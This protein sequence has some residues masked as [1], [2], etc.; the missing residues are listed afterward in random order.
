MEASTTLGSWLVTNDGNVSGKKR[1]RIA[2]HKKKAWRVTSNVEDV[3]QFLETK[4]REERTGIVVSDLPT[5]DLLV[6]DDAPDT[7]EVPYNK[8][9]GPLK[10]RKVREIGPLKCYAILTP[11]SAVNDP[12][13]SRNRVR[14][15]EERID[16]LIK[17]I[18]DQRRAQG[19]IPKN[20]LQSMKDHKA[21]TAKLA[22]KAKPEKLRSKF[23]FDLWGS[24]GDCIMVGDKAVAVTDLSDEVKTY[25]MEKTGKRVYNRP[26][27]MFNK[28]TGLPA[29]EYPHPG[30]SYNPTFEDHQALV[31]KACEVEVKELEKEA[32]IRRQVGPMFTKIPVVEKEATWMTEMSQGLAEDENNETTTEQPIVRPTKPK[33]RRQKIKA[34]VLKLREFRRLKLK[35]AK[36]RMNAL[37][38]L[39]KIKIELDDDEELNAA[40]AVRR[41][42]L[43]AKKMFKPAVVGRHKY[44]APE[45]E[46]NLSEDIAGNM[47]NLKVEGN[48]LLDRYKSLQKRNVI[49]PRIR[50]RVTLKYKPKTYVKRSHKETSGRRAQPK[51]NKKE[52]I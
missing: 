4:R 2:K 28:T 41:K 7:E 48:I 5:K 36:K 19:K 10:K 32:K 45:I 17:K 37:N 12:L 39:N 38:R 40:M 6:I 27:S 29:I 9:V 24:Q 49:E 35:N 15:P 11:S 21:H 25:T 1:K 20:L 18:Q 33:T 46:V 34:K 3:E 52:F 30:T 50:Q 31:N 47:R 23:D 42:E 44:V 13:K 51:K 16:P 43:A 22:K 14:L 26:K 8:P